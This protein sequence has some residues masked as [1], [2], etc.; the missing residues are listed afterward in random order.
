MRNCIPVLVVALLTVTA[1]GRP[2]ET[3][4]FGCPALEVVDVATLVAPAPGAI[5]VPT[6]VGSV[7]FTTPASAIVPGSSAMSF[8]GFTLTLTPGNPGVETPIVG[9]PITTDA[10]G[11][12]SSSIPTLQPHTTYNAGVS[13]PSGGVC[14]FSESGQLGSFTTQ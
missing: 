1:C 11:L 12:S 6:T 3:G 5:N 9:G 14:H 7:T 2:A 10:A 4:G 8:V 13:L